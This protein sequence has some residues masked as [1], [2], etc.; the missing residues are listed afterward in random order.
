MNFS[1]NYLHTVKYLISLLN[2]LYFMIMKGI[3]LILSSTRSE[4]EN[5]DGW[6]LRKTQKVTVGEAKVL[7]SEMINVAELSLEKP[8]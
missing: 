7:F 8:L 3:Q 6:T 1:A 5:Y 2:T 4:M